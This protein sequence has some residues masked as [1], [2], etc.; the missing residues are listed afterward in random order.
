M[1]GDKIRAADQIGG[2]DRFR[3]EPQMRH[4]HAAGFLGIINEITLGVIVRAFADDFDGILVRAHRAVGAQAVKHRANHIVRLG[5]KFVVHRQAGAGN[6]VIDADGEMIFRLLRSEIVEHG[7][8]HRRREFLR[9]QTVTAADNLRHRLQLAEAVHQSFRQ[10]GDG[11][12]IKRFACRARFL[13]AIQ[14][15]DGFH[16]GR[17]CFDELAVSNGRY[18]RT[19]STPTFSPFLT[20]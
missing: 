17:Q 4:G 10:R 14:N 7:L 9:G 5:R 20:R 3:P 8:D 15:R 16:A 11:I 1:A 12:L 13:G 2:T 18:N 19:F 6:I